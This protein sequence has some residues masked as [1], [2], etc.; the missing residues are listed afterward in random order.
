MQ[1]QTIYKDAF[2]AAFMNLYQLYQTDQIYACALVLNKFLLIDNLAISTQRSIFAEDEDSA[3]Y[4]AAHDRWNVSKWRYRSLPSLSQD[5]S[6]FKMTSVNEVGLLDLDPSSIES[7]MKSESTNHLSILLNAIQQTK[8]D[9]AQS[10]GIELDNILFFITLPTQPEIEIYSAQ[11]L[12]TPST[13]L[14]DFL[15]SKQPLQLDSLPKR[16]KLSQHDK[17]LLI[18]LAQIVEIQPYNYLH[19]ANEV[20]LLSLEK[21]Y[22]TTNLYIQKLID[23][24]V[25]MTSD[26][27]GTFAMEKEEILQRIN[28]FYFNAKSSDEALSQEAIYKFTDLTP[29]KASV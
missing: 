8:V 22:A 6:Q 3:Q 26:P 9:L 25:A 19:V 27:K 2:V 20:Y 24:I 21:S 5:L 14:E 18:D 4:L 28:Q 23:S 10:Y 15:K 7:S 13:Q 29:D 12:N 11:V 17:D 1:N 16:M